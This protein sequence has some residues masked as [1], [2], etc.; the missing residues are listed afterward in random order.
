MANKDK[1]DR[2]SNDEMVVLTPND[3]IE[4]TSYRVKWHNF[5]VIYEELTEAFKLLNRM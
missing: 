1:I 4:N 5:Q 2:Y 3:S